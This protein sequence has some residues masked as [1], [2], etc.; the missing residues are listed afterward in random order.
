MDDLQIAEQEITITD[1]AAKRV[2]KIIDQEGDDSMMLRIAIGGIL[3]QQLQNE[4]AQCGRDVSRKRR[5][6][7]VD[8]LVEQIERTIRVKR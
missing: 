7:R 2:A 6:L 3:C 5:R 4:V 8:M 1:A